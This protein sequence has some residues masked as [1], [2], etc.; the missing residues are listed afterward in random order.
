MGNVCARTRI[1]GQ[2]V[3]L[4]GRPS[5]LVALPAAARVQQRELSRE[6]LAREQQDAAASDAATDEELAAAREEVAAALAAA[7]QQPLVRL[8]AGCVTR[9][10]CPLPELRCGR[11]GFHRSALCIISAG[12]AGAAAAVRIPAARAVL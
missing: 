12:P 4:H 11:N 10:S 2:R 1:A 8:E 3:C 7:P 5:H 9:Q 6:L